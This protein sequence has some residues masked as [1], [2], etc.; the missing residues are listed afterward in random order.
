MS[1]SA[2]ILTN[3]FSSTEGGLSR[4]SAEVKQL[5][6]EL[7]GGNLSAAQQDFLTLSNDAENP[8]A[9]ATEAAY[10]GS[11]S[12]TESN[13]ARQAIDSVLRSLGQNLQSGNLA[14]AQ[15][16]FSQMQQ[17]LAEDDASQPGNS[18]RSASAAE[19][20]KLLETFLNSDFAAISTS[21]TNG[22]SGS[23]GGSLLSLVSAGPS[24]ASDAEPESVPAVDLEA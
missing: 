17:A 3:S 1:T 19:I 8:A 16:A 18:S 15:Q 20:M 2:A 24:S 12:E 13:S 7:A 10:S 5:G 21:G 4:A 6:K 11:S 9:P 22:S 14:A 23:P